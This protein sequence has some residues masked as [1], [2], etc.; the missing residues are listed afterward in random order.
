MSVNIVFYIIIFSIFCSLI[1]NPTFN[2]V[3]L[4]LLD[5]SFNLIC[6]SSIGTTSLHY[7]HTLINSKLS[8]GV[9]H[10]FE[11]PFSFLIRLNRVSNTESHRH[12]PDF[13]VTGS[14]FMFSLVK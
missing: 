4:S 1:C 5:N 14:D 13:T 6:D 3:S 11:A 10:L 7:L 9:L 12:K 2:V 8:F